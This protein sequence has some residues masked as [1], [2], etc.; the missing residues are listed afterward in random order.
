MSKGLLEEEGVLAVEAAREAVEAH[1]VRRPPEIGLP[2]RFSEKG[3][4]FVTLH[5]HPQNQLR[6]CI[7]Y[8]EPIFSLAEAI[9]RAAAGACEDPRFPPLR[10]HELDKVVVEVSVLS[11][12]EPI[13]ASSPQEVLG[14]IEVGRDGLIISK[15]PYRGLLLPQVAVE[16]GWDVTMFL[17][18]L[19]RKAG[20]GPDD[21]MDADLFRF[22]SMVFAET[23]PRGK[24][25]RRG[26]AD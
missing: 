11:V 23:E 3:G 6:G 21:W 8:P 22:E 17:Q 4:A 24:V 20:L 7:G 15:G 18:N 14:S 13:H 12:P 2:S 10:S 1:V 16:W 5:T 25:M 9:V 26:K 19:C